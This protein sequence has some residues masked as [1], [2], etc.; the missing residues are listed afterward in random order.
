MRSGS[1]AIAK[2]IIDEAARSS[3]VPERPGDLTMPA[4]V[5]KHLDWLFSLIVEAPDGLLPAW[6]EDGRPS[7]PYPEATGYFLSL[8]AYLYHMTGQTRLIQPATATAHALAGA[9]I[10]SIGAGRHGQIFLFD[11]VVCLRGLNDFLVVFPASSDRSIRP[12]IT[13]A[14]ERLARTARR[15]ID[16]RRAGFGFSAPEESRWS[17]RYN[18]HLLKSLQQLHACRPDLLD[19][20]EVDGEIRRFLAERFRNGFFHVD[21]DR[22]RVYLHAH[23]YAMEGLLGARP[24][25]TP[26]ILARLTEMAERLATAQLPNGALPR[27]WPPVG[28]PDPAVDTTAQVVRLWQCLD[29]SGFR[30]AIARALDFVATMAAPGGGVRYTPAGTHL[31][32][33]TTIFAIQALLWRAWPPEGGRIV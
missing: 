18:V 29:P 13:A 2:L 24:R 14:A 11:T 1:R 28:R 26:S 8:L 12:A 7:Y 15:L 16:E 27:F 23:C 4:E 19:S 22:S 32:S 5:E 30:D 10:G 25:L 21:E 31:N 9:L 17:R 3:R 6:T 33:W 20:E